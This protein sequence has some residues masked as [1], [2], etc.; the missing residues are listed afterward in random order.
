MYGKLILR[1]DERTFLA[2]TRLLEKTGISFSG[3]LKLD[4]Q[5]DYETVSQYY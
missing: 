1:A 2:K 5:S 3:D 4:I